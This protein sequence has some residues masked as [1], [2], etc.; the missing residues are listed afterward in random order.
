[1]PKALSVRQPWASLISEGLKHIEIRSRTWSYRGPLVICA[2][3]TPYWPDAFGGRR[4]GDPLPHGCA[5]CVA[6]M[7]AC[8]PLTPQDA[9]AAGLD[10]GEL[11]PED[12]EGQWAWVLANARPV[13]HVPVKGQLAPWDWA[14]PAL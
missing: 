7:V 2:T 4:R 12:C 5:V 6:D 14:G 1:M 13:T 9:Q 10:T 11:T 8:R 3:A